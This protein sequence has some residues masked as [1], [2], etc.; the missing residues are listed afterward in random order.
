MLCDRSPGYVFCST[1][2]VIIQYGS[3]FGVQITPLPRLSEA[4][5]AWVLCL[6]FFFSFFFE[7]FLP[8][9]HPQVLQA[10]VLFL[11]LQPW[12]RPLS[13]RALLRAEVRVFLP[14]PRRTGHVRHSPVSAAGSASA[15]CS[16][17]E[18][19][20]EGLCSPSAKYPQMLALS[21]QC[22]TSH[23]SFIC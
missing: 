12:D 2:V 1:A 8:F 19:L 5:W 10:H 6:F 17:S 22:L 15:L 4:L 20:H 14:P 7:H 23:P 21:S 13:S 11:L 16:G 3:C 18:V 9:W